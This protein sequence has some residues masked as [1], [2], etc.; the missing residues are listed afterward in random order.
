MDE[1]LKKLL[2][3]EVLTE[4]TRKELE[5][6]FKQKIDEESKK[7]REEATISVNADLHEKWT[8]ERDTLIEALDAKVSE[9]LKEELSELKEDIE[10]FRDLETEYAEKI[11]E[12]KSEMATGLKKDMDSLIEK[13]DA[14]LEIRLTKELSELHEDIEAQRKKNFGK[15]VFEAFVEDFTTHY[16]ADDSVE[17][18]LQETQQRLEDALKALEE[19][20]K[21]S[22]KLDRAKKMDDVLKPLTGRP[23]EVMEAILKS[24]DTP[25]LSDAY[26]TYVGK[27]LKET[28]A[29][30]AEQKTSEKETPVL[31]EG[32]KKSEKKAPQGVTKTGD[33]NERITEG[34]KLDQQQGKISEEVKAKLRHLAGIN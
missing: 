3:A 9:V 14:F 21:K 32:E 2:A 19:S 24:V 16:P 30:V 31:A 12:A 6:A 7:A 11:V 22:A 17:G 1:L 28:A 15:R 23:R 13:L 4:D 10:R 34:A 33:D 5:T 8:T 25:M 27:V 20:E 26:K 29:P 18:K